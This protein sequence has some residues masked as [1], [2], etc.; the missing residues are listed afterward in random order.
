MNNKSDEH[1]KNCK[2]DRYRDLTYTVDKRGGK[3]VLL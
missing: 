1:Y 3:I 2:S